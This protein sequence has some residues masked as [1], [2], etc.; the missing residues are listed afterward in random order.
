MCPLSFSGW[1][2]NPTGLLSRAIRVA[3]SSTQPARFHAA[4][5]LPRGT[6]IERRRSITYYDDLYEQPQW[7]FPN[8]HSMPFPTSIH[9][10]GAGAAALSNAAADVADHRTPGGPNARAPQ[11]LP[12]AN[13]SPRR[14]LMSF[15]GAANHGDLS[16]RRRIVAECKQMM[17]RMTSTQSS[18][19][20]HAHGDGHG[21]ESGG[22]QDGNHRSLCVSA[23]YGFG[24]AMRVK[25]QSDFCL[26]PA[27]DTPFR[28]SL[29]DSI[30]SGCIPV[31]FHPMTDHANEWI[32]NGWKSAGRV[33]VPRAA[34]VA[35][36]ISLHALLGTSLPRALLT[37]MKRVLSLNA[38]KFTISLDDDPDDQLHALLIGA[39]RLARRLE[40]AHRSPRARTLDTPHMQVCHPQRTCRGRGGYGAAAA[41]S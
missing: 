9:M 11:R 4:D 6:T 23:G 30:A 37:K 5:Y 40:T 17:S 39:S 25:L 15:V 29:A 7:S 22:G 19:R 2:V 38:R 33:L 36:E 14:H 13:E 3:Y 28:K 8:L 35:G 26:E 16:V 27:G 31:L 41:D 18:A 12:W 32:W 34:Y 1:F 10:R 24:E 21:A 20:S